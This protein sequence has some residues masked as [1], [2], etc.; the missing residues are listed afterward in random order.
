MWKATEQLDYREGQTLGR[1]D[2]PAN[3]AFVVLTG[4]IIVRRN[5]RKVATL[6]PGEV[7]GEMTLLDGEPRSADLIAAEDS[8]VLYI[9]RREFGKLL[10]SN[11]KLTTKVLKSL[12][13]RLREADRNL[14]S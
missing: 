7:V 10:E 1:Q 9:S 12:A 6:G 5:G 8:S 13:F 2:K 4:S 3:E 11:F 14:Y